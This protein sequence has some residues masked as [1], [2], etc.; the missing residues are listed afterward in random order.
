MEHYVET[1][2]FRQKVFFIICIF[3]F[4]MTSSSFIRL[5]VLL[6]LIGASLLKFF[7]W[8]YLFYVGLVLMPMKTVGVVYLGFNAPLSLLLFIGATLGAIREHSLSIQPLANTINVRMILVL[9]VLILSSFQSFYLP[10]DPV[11]ILGSFRNYPWIKSLSRIAYIGALVCLVFFIQS[12]ASKKQIFF[13][14]LKVL[15]YASIVYS[16]IG[17]I[18]FFLSFLN[19]SSIFGTQIVNISGNELPR[20]HVLEWEPLY[21]GI[22]LLTITPLMLCFALRKNQ[23]FSH[24][25]ITRASVINSVALFLTFSRGA[26]IG[27]FFVLCFLFF[28]NHTILLNHPIAK[29]LRYLST[30]KRFVFFTL[31]L[32]ALPFFFLFGE[33]ILT[34]IYTTIIYPILGSINPSSGKFWS[35]RNRLLILELG[36]QAFLKHPF[37][38]IGYENFSFYAG[39]IYIHGLLD[40]VINYSE[41]NN[42]PLKILTETGIIGFTVLLCIMIRSFADLIRSI[43]RTQSYELKIALEG[44]FMSLAAIAVQSLFFSNILSLHLWVIIGMT[45][46]AMNLCDKQKTRSFEE[47]EKKSTC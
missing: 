38:G 22:Y 43:K 4:F 5:I 23:L 19:I 15:V 41:I 12:F 9:I 18:G 44:L 31:S 17:I 30:N 8:T 27:Y 29:Y 11:V 33:Q 21:F 47:N 34:F 36:V 25:F 2:T 32:Y 10:P 7:S 16:L 26:W 3:S 46:A 6:S 20:I 35:T 24:R 14:L 45:I 42:L 28:K 39:N 40:F 37:F 1:V 13:R